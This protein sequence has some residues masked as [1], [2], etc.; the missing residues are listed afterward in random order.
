MAPSATWAWVT[1]R[2][3]SRSSRSRAW[4]HPSRRYWTVPT[5]IS[6]GLYMYSNGEVS[7]VMKAFLDWIVGPEGQKI[8]EDEG[9]VPLQ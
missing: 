3:I 9:F 1:S 2:P 5:T 4:R 8:V 7:G 6:R